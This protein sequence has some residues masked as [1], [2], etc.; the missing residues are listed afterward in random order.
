VLEEGGQLVGE[1]RVPA[2]ELLYVG[3]AAAAS[4]ARGKGKGTSFNDTVQ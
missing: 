4:L 3:V 1:R 2:D